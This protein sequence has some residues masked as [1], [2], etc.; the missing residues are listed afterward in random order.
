MNYL[1]SSTPEIVDDILTQG[2]SYLFVFEVPDYPN[3]LWTAQLNFSLLGYAPVNVPGTPDISDIALYNVFLDSEKSTG[4]PVGNL[5]SY[6]ILTEIGGE[7]E[8]VGLLQPSAVNVSANKFTVNNTLVDGDEVNFTPDQAGNILPDPLVEGVSYFVV[9]VSSN[10]FQISAT[11][12]GPVLDITTQGIGAFEVWKF[13]PPSPAP[14]PQRVSLYLGGVTIEPNPLV[15]YSPVTP[16][17]KALTA[18]NETINTILSQPE[19]SASFN[20]QSYTL[21]N[22][23]DLF[24]IRNSLQVQVAGELRSMGLVTKP[25]ARIIQNRFV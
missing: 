5:D 11:S 21:H 8:L 18:V 4:L 20:G 19:S 25:T 2:D 15:P 10:N 9:N 3:D 16:N 22:I 17:Q 13:I 24:D 7:I 1:S 23:K 14:P 12:G 6:L